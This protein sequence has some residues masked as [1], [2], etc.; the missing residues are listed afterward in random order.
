[1]TGEGKAQ[2]TPLRPRRPCPEC[3]R[4]SARD[5]Y[6]FCSKRCK[7]IDLNRWLKGA[8]VIPVRDDEED[9]PDLT[10]TPTPD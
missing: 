6:P 9:A 3:G 4:P 7:D 10:D 1:M 8:Y 2:V 5:T